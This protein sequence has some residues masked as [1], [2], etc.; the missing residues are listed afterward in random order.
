MRISFHF[1]SLWFKRRVS[2][3]S[4]WRRRSL[5]GL[6]WALPLQTEKKK[7]SLQRPLVDAWWAAELR[8]PNQRPSEALGPEWEQWQGECF[9]LVAASYIHANILVIDAAVR[10]KTAK[11]EKK[12]QCQIWGN[13]SIRTWSFSSGI[14]PDLP[15]V[16][17]SACESPT[18]L[19]VVLLPLQLVRGKCQ[20]NAWKKDE[21]AWK[22]I[23]MFAE[24]TRSSGFLLER[25]KLFG[26][27]FIKIQTQTFST[28]ARR[29]LLQER[30]CYF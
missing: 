28:L 16:H 9:R 3:T 20:K 7:N 15:R 23:W 12:N 1:Y 10:Q 24:L 6:L 2:I 26:L 5:D 25:L 21:A 14:Y 19:P 18:P 11:R 13:K 30:Y 17:V 8:C 27:E 29:I 22:L 4:P